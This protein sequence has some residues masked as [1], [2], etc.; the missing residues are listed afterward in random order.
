MQYILE[1]EPEPQT[2]TKTPDVMQAC[3]LEVGDGDVGVVVPG[4]DVAE[5]VL[6]VSLRCG[7]TQVEVGDQVT[8]AKQE[9]SKN[10]ASHHNV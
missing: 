8:P 3:D 10:Q 7:N 6:V 5:R 9:D 2:R 4:N 1:L